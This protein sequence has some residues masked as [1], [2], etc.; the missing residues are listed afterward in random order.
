[1]NA[2]LAAFGE[3]PFI[4]VC[5][6]VDEDVDIFNMNDVMWA[7]V[8]RTRLERDMNVIGNVMGFSRDPFGHYRSKLAIDATAPLDNR[9]HYRRAMVINPEINLDA[10]LADDG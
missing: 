4:K 1:M 5:I 3:V 9:E 8:T 7:V 6:A 2:I 10:W